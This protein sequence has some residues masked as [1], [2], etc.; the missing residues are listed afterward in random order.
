MINNANT[1]DCQTEKRRVGLSMKSVPFVL[2]AC[3]I[4]AQLAG[5]GANE[6]PQRVIV[7]GKVAFEGQPVANGQ[8]LFYPTG[9]TRGPVS[10]GPIKDGQYVAKA[11]GGVPI[12]THRVEIT[13]F[14]APTGSG[15]FAITE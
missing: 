4:L 5:C 1:D 6:G 11:R 8:I 7:Q 13:A 2:L 12:G 10:G 9:D 14:R 15:G 3:V